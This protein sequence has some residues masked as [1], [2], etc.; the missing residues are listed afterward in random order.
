MARVKLT[1][2]LYDKMHGG[3]Q[4]S[5]KTW[6]IDTGGL[7]AGTVCTLELTRHI[8]YA[9]VYLNAVVWLVYKLTRCSS[10]NRCVAYM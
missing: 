1:S 10:A 8:S 4:S 6:A 9:D 3:D 5:P 2:A 7:S